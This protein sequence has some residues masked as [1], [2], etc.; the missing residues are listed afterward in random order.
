[1]RAWRRFAVEVRIPMPPTRV[2]IAEDQ[3]LLRS[4]LRALLEPEEDIE[5]VGD[6]ADG[7]G[8]VDGV[9]ATH[10]DVVLMDIQLPGLDGIEATRR[11]LA[12]RSRARI[13]IVTTFDLDEYVYGA[14]RAGAAGFLLKSA[15]PERLVSAV[16]T[17]ASG[18]SVLDPAPLH[19]L[20]DEYL[21]RPEPDGELAARID[22][23]SD[24]E[25]EVWLLIARGM[26]NA[27]ISA[28]LFLSEGTVKTHVTRLLGKLGVP[29]RAAAVVLAYESGLVRAGRR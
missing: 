21:H 2:F 23:L 18:E 11:I 4:G 14:L 17:I 22:G 7:P 20:I 24:R 27:Q 1:M 12:A 16:R 3:T 9:I 6:A 19:R 8:A 10:P 15:L 28:E 5:V 25:R 29:S 26:S 13:L